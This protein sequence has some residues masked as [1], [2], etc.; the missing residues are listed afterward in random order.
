MLQISAIRSLTLGAAAFVALSGGEALA[1]SR[2]QIRIVGS[3][4]VAP[5]ASAVAEEFG[6]TSPYRTPIVEQTG[7]GGGFKL[8]C[9]G[10]GTNYPDIS[11]ASRP[12][13]Q[14]EIALCRSN[15]V[16]GIIEIRI[17]SDGIVLA[18]DKRGPRLQLSLREIYLALGA[19]VP[20]DGRLTTNPHQ[21]WSDI[22]GDLPDIQI[23]VLGPPPTSGTRD[24]FNELAMGGGAEHVTDEVSIRIGLPA[25]CREGNKGCQQAKAAGKKQW[26]DPTAD[27]TDFTD[28]ETVTFA[29]MGEMADE[30]PEIFE[31]IAHFVRED[32]PYVEAGE[33]D[34][35]IV[36]KL[37]ATSETYGIFGFSFL[38]QNL[39]KLHA[40]DVAKEGETYVKP[41]FETIESGD[42]PISRSLF[43][44][45]KKQH[46]GSIPGIKDYMLE[47]LSDRQLGTPEQFFADGALTERGLVPVTGEVR[48]RMIDRAKNLTTMDTGS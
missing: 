19:Y 36:Q 16:T 11:N 43:F 10:V 37:M 20:V 39:D 31:S 47:F 30:M 17:G 40:A 41:R 9:G 29:T 42:Y 21:T 8:F 44:Y 24:A 35:L 34:N 14:S 7:T 6:R 45:V 48:K 32:G 26:V 12:I 15:G 18:N 38:D 1:Q 23:E 27:D 4:T 22:R 33:S 13:K 46:I 3:S 25:S 5:F 2:E 28:I